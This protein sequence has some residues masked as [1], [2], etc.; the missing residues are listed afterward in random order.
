MSVSIPLA[1]THSWPAEVESWIRREPRETVLVVDSHTAGN[2]TRIV[3]GGDAIADLVVGDVPAVRQHLRDDADW[4]RTRLV[5]EPRGGA[6]TCAVLPVYETGE[7]WD[8]GAVILEPGSYPPMCGHCMLGFTV[9]AA[10][11]NLVPAVRWVEDTLSFGIRTP[12]GVIGA[13]A[14]REAGAVVSATIVNV[15]SRVV[16][17]WP[18]R[19]GDAD[20]VVD[21]VY[22]GDYY[23]CV[24]AVELGLDLVRSEADTIVGLAREL[25]EKATATPILDPRTGE[26]LDVYQ[27]LFHRR[28]KAE[29]LRER[30]VVVAPP[31]VIDRS[32][33]GTGSSALLALLADR[34]EIRT[35]EVLETESIIGSEFLLRAE[36]VRMEG[37]IVVTVPSITSSAHIN[38]FS[39]VVVDSRDA[40]R[41]GF[42]PL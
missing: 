11:M 18:I 13:T 26:P 22:G 40:L 24:D 28:S 42:A 7:D 12:A 5:H 8:I 34:G 38:G 14:R 3:V 33:C 27:V 25:A 35:G 23:L 10:E 15:E 32:P 37:G 39:A 31:G 17:S 36:S 2:P 16:T 29:A 4:L 19:I 6:L 30:V 41:D 20:V 1:S 21:L 9:V